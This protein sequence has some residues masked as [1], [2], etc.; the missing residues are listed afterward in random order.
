MAGSEHPS[1]KI[2]IW[3]TGRF[4]EMRPAEMGTEHSVTTGRFREAKFHWLLSGNQSWKATVASVP[5]AACGGRWNR[6]FTANTENAEAVVRNASLVLF[7]AR[8]LKL[9]IR[10]CRLDESPGSPAI[11]GRY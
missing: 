8:T 11:N 3:L 10:S 7:V 9:R 5:V 4:G 6:T 2:R 1:R